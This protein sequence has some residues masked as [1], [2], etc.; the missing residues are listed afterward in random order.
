MIML[1][2][3][4]KMKFPQKITNSL[5]AAL[6]GVS[7]TTAAIL[8]A[9]AEAFDILSGAIAI[10]SVAAQYSY[11]DKQVNYLNNDSKGRQEMMASTKKKYGVNEDPAANA[12]LER[13]MTRLS[14]S[15]AQTDPTIREQ[16]YSYFVNNQKTF[17]AFCT[18][19][20]NMS[21][22][23]GLFNVLNY[24]EDEIAFVV[25]HEMGHGQRNDP[26]DGVKKQ[27][28]ITLLA[29]LYQSQNPNAASVISSQV[30]A[31]IGTAKG[32]TLPM[33]KRADKSAF[34]YC[35]RA[36]YNVGAGAAVWQRVIEK[37]GVSKE[38]FV[39]EIFNPSD[40][41]GNI[42]RRDNYNENIT[43][44]SNDVVKVD[45]ET[46]MI[47]VHNQKIGKPAPYASMSTLER[48]YLV[49]GNLAAVYH[50]KGTSKAVLTAT[51]RDGIIYLGDQDVITVSPKD[52]G[53]AWV[54]KLNAANQT[55]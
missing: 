29:A 4:D 27:M 40:H 5:L 47:S 39:S 30:L 3:C 25:G 19:G 1:K 32:V 10:A 11:L 21:V 8:P 34:E 17:N 20:H 18:L 53:A 38:G 22:N 42:S 37:M 28:P 9:R 44:W 31:N 24:N 45:K 23:I 49:A 12:M 46:G 14:A 54:N 48:A 50:D 33:E 36:G 51:N 41:P 2:G 15:I 16:P 35:S 52:N 6:V 13:I 26:A 55:K 7:L 43:D